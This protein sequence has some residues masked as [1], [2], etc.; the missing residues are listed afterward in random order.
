MIQ[1]F[2]IDV[3]ELEPVIER[4]EA[5]LEGVPTSLSII[6]LIALAIFMQKP[7]ISREHLAD[8]SFEVSKFICMQLMGAEDVILDKKDMN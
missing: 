7:E 3:D 8:V 4:L 5:A 6:S 2:S 1:D